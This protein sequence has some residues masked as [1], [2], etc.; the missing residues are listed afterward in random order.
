ML[1]APLLALAIAALLPACKKPESTEAAAAGS[2]T[3]DS[4]K[5]RDAAASKDDADQV[6]VKKANAY[7]NAANRLRGFNEV[8]ITETAQRW[9]EEDIQK[10]KGGDFTKIRR[11]SSVFSSNTM[12]LLDEAL[13][14]PAE[15]AAADAAARELRQVV[16]Q[17]LP[18]WKALEAYNTAR[19]YEDDAGAEGKRMLPQYLAGIDALEAALAKFNAEVDVLSKEMQK[20]NAA[21]FAAEGKLLELHTLNALEAG[22][23]ILGVFE[24]EDDFK[25]PAKIEQANGYLAEME[26]GIEGIRSEHA[27]RK[28]ADQAATERNQRTLPMIENYM[29]IASDLEQMAGKYR[30]ARSNP[31]RFNDAVRNYNSAVDNYNRMR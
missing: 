20:K 13:A 16:D 1:K 30:E 11:D 6:W 10:A 9:R 15:T 27:T 8:A 22:K 25:N 14:M 7:I 4:S 29:S 24:S 12:E 18:N 19:K 5:G 31:R 3:T 28:A 2:A 23:N 17:Y 26:K 21:K